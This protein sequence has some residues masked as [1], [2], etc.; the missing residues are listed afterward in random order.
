MV[1]RKQYLASVGDL[2]RAGLACEALVLTL[3]AEDPRVQQV[4]ETWLEDRDAAKPVVDV[5]VRDVLK[6]P[7]DWLPSLLIQMFAVATLG[8]AGLVSPHRPLRVEPDLTGLDIVGRRSKGGGAHVYEYVWIYYRAKIKVPADSIR[9]L[10][11][12]HGRLRQ[13]AGAGRGKDTDGRSRVQTAIREVERWL[14]NMGA[15]A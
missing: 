13:A 6:L 5:L 4:Y 9:K 14:S 15:P 10:G 12:E 2:E 8:G 3:L 7:Y 1:V 11:A